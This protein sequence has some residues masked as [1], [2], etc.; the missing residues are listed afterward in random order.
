MHTSNIKP[1]R[2]SNLT[3]TNETLKN[4]LKLLAPGVTT[5]F[6]DFIFPSI[7][8]ARLEKWRES[9]YETLIELIN[10]K[11]LTIDDLRNNVE[12]ITILK[13]CMLVASR[14][15]QEEKL[16]LL[17]NIILKSID[18]SFQTDYKLIFNRLVDELT[19]THIKILKKSLENNVLLENLD[20]YEDFYKLIVENDKSFDV[21]R[22][23]FIFFITELTT[24]NLLIISNDVDRFI[25]VRE[26]NGFTDG[27]ARSD[28]PNILITDLAKDFIKYILDEF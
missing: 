19:I 3:T 26:N 22:Q 24:R 4:G 16:Q 1:P 20:T 13:Q 14:N 18:S 11:G 28:L 6:I 9:V 7:H 5:L 8:E 15:H 10:K 21:N 25:M 17:K 12:F 27:G 23:Q 2:K